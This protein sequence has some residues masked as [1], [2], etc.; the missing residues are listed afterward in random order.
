MVKKSNSELKQIRIDYS[1]NILIYFAP[2]LF[3]TT[4]KNFFCNNPFN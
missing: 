2:L 4:F 3:M 1:V